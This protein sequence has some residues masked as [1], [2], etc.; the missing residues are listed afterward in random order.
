METY[1]AQALP[2]DMAMTREAMVFNLP[3]FSSLSRTIVHYT[4]AILSHSRHD[5]KE[6]I[7]GGKNDSCVRINKKC[8]IR[9]TLVNQLSPI[10]CY[11]PQV[12]TLRT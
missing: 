11:A 10:P 1:Y 2:K 5:M 12:R 3:Y 8:E 9:I 7:K 4:Y 6:E